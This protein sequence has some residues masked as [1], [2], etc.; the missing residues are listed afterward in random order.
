[1]KVEIDFDNDDVVDRI[2]CAALKSRIES[3]EEHVRAYKAGTYD[4][5][6]IFDIDPDEDLKRI[7]KQ[8]KAFKRTYN[9]FGGDL[10]E[11]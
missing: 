6:P 10:Y 1:M 4:S 2:I 5:I 9:W 3:F 11:V 8:L 7:K